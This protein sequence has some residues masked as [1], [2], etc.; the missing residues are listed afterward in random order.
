M[1]QVLTCISTNNIT[2]L[3]EL[4]YA[5]AKLVCVKIGILSKI[6]KEKSKPGWEFRLETQI[7]NPT[8]TAKSDK[9][10]TAGINRNRKKRQHRKTL[11]YNLRKYTRKYWQRKED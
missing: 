5:G 1:N 6:T 10:K 3:N 4:I 2:E 8:K 11:Q 7:K 9:K